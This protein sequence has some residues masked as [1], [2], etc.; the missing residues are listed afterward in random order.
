MNLTRKPESTVTGSEPTLAF[1]SDFMVVASLLVFLRERAL[2]SPS[3]IVVLFGFFER[4]I[5]D[6]KA[7]GQL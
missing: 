6:E 5:D 2:M 4:G 3:V 1:R 7:N